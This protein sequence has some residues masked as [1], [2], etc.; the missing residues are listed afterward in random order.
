MIHNTKSATAVLTA[1]LASPVLGAVSLGL[2]PVDNSAAM[3]GY[4][5]YDIQFTTDADWTAA[6]MLLDLSVGNIYQEPEGWPYAGVTFG[7]PNPAFFPYYPTA[8]F[9]TYLVGS[10]TTTSIAGGGGDVGGDAYQFDT[11]EL[12]VSWYNRSETDIGTMTLGRVTI[13][14]DAVGTWSL[15]S[16]TADEQRVNLVGTISQGVMAI[17]A[18]ASAAAT[19]AAYLNSE[20]YQRSLPRPTFER[21]HVDLTSH[22]SPVIPFPEIAEPLTVTGD[23]DATLPEPGTV[24]LV[25]MGGLA[26]L[27]RRR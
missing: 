13:T 27:R 4:L 16:I 22:L 19:L 20:E 14:D 6:A 8:E 17:D 3:T 15:L 18:E 12:D 26:L 1:L 5:T 9:D 21:E 7:P 24:L 23:A 25:G 10:V 2:V 11:Q